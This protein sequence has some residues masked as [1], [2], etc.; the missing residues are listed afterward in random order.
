MNI[1]IGLVA[2]IGLAVILWKVWIEG[3]R[4]KKAEHYLALLLLV[5]IA[6]ALLL[7]PILG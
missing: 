6:L 4:E 7:D 1:F 2:V 5:I 3:I